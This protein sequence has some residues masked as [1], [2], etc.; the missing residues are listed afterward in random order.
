MKIIFII[1]LIFNIQHIKQADRKITIC[2][3]SN[4]NIIKSNISK[5]EI[6]INALI[7]V[8]SNNNANAFNKKENAVG[9]LQI[10]PILIRDINRFS[11]N[12]YTLEDRWDLKKSKQIFNEYVRYYIN[13]TTKF[14]EIARK[15]NGG[16]LG[17]K[18]PETKIYWEKVKRILLNKN[19]L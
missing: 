17:H 2:D 16:P 6:F 19:V 14:Q 11:K 9:V 1:L 10:R 5:Y 8:E 15:W 12:K 3:N 7:K 4:K 18:K 13:D